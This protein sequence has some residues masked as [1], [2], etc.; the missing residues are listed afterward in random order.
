VKSTR[1]LFRIAAF[2]LFIT[3]AAFNAMAQTTAQCAP[4][5]SDAAV[6]NFV[7]E[8]SLQVGEFRPLLKTETGF[9]QTI[10]ASPSLTVTDLTTPI[11]PPEIMPDPPRITGDLVPPA[12][13][14][15]VQ[16]FFTGQIKKVGS[17]FVLIVQ[18]KKVD[19]GAL[20]HEE[21]TPFADAAGADAAGVANATAMINFV[22]TDSSRQGRETGDH[23]IDPHIDLI[24]DKLLLKP[25]EVSKVKVVLTDCDGLRL[26]GR[27]IEANLQLTRGGELVQADTLVRVTDNNGERNGDIGAHNPGVINYVVKFNYVDMMGV[28]RDVTDAKV[29]V[30][31]GGIGRD[32]WQMR[33]DILEEDSHLYKRDDPQSGRFSGE[34]YFVHKKV[35]MVFVFKA[36]PS[37]DGSVFV[38]VPD[39]FNGFGEATFRRKM[40]SGQDTA[41]QRVA[42]GLL[43][44]KEEAD[45]LKPSFSIDPANKDFQAGLQHVVFRGSQTILAYRRSPPNLV[46]RREDWD[47]Q[48]GAGGGTPITEAMT[49]SGVY[50]FTRTERVPNTQPYTSGYTLKTFTFVVKRLTPEQKGIIKK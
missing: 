42:S 27:T 20:I 44:Q 22:S 16:F 47:E 2:C 6:Y 34:R 39:T 40:I 49:R 7:P 48:T 38:D 10:E 28:P 15:F 17:G 26:K 36:R 32:L 5:K 1:G 23:A 18:L 14:P 45:D 9:I 24:I 13:P 25:N 46:N 3:I 50:S 37:S 8:P 29:V 21:Q 41:E 19:G 11:L 33:V 35:S 31:D 12:T 43:D 30:I 4:Q